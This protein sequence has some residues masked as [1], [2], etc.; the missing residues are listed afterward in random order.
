MLRGWLV[1][2]K[3]LVEE[4]PREPKY[5]W[6]PISPAGA[7]VM[8]GWLG[9][10]LS[11]V[12]LSDYAIAMVPFRFGVAE[13]EFAT[14]AS[15]FSGL[16]LLTMGLAALW[17]SAMMRAQRWQVITTAV[18]LLVAGVVVFGLLLVFVL[19]VPLALRASAGEVRLGVKKAVAKTV[20]LGLLFG[21]S[22]LVTG[23]WSLR[24]RRE[25]ERAASGTTT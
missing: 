3:I 23:V 21:G 18:V 1:P 8:L 12:A 6:A 7:W 25:A 19:D 13:W 5:E 17:L 14:I 2:E 4:A 20:M 9:V 10:L 15:V 22:Y 16:P 11:A 24:R